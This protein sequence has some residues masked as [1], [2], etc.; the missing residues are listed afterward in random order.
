MRV[1]CPSTGPATSPCPELSERAVP[2][3]LLVEEGSGATHASTTPAPSLSPD[4]YPYLRLDTE[5]ATDARFQSEGA[6]AQS[7]AV[8][9]TTVTSAFARYAGWGLSPDSYVG[10]SLIG[11]GRLVQMRTP[12]WNCPLSWRGCRAAARVAPTCCRAC[13]VERWL[14]GEG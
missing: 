3:P 10:S 8:G 13:W 12:V 4:R 5:G 2:T 11:R 7:P 14:A 1:P 6:L 9:L